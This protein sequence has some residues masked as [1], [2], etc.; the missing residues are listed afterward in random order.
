M[1]RR[2]WEIQTR[3]EPVFPLEQTITVT[4]PTKQSTQSS[5]RKSCWFLL[6]QED[7]A[8]EVEM[9]RGHI[10]SHPFSDTTPVPAMLAPMRVRYVCSLYG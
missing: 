2:H 6:L 10:S 3:K 7:Y 8:A 4:F 9:F 1:T 5:T